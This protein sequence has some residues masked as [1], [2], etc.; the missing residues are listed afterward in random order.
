MTT[1]NA[2]TP[3]QEKALKELLSSPGMTVLLL[4]NKDID[5]VC[6][7]EMLESK[8]QDKLEAIEQKFL[9]DN[10]DS[11]ALPK[12]VLSSIKYPNLNFTK[13]VTKDATFSLFNDEHLQVSGKL[14]ELFMNAKDVDE[15]LSLGVYCRERLNPY[16][17]IYAW[18]SACIHREDTRRVQLPGIAENLPSKFFTKAVIND[19]RKLIY[20]SNLDRPIVKLTTESVANNISE[21]LRLNYFREDIAINQHHY[22][23]HIIYPFTG[24]KSV[25]N[26]DRRGELFYYLHNQMLRRINNERFCLGITAVTPLQM[27]TGLTCPD[28]YYPKM[29]TSLGSRYTTGRPDNAEISEIQLGGQNISPDRIRIWLER[30]KNSI[31][32]GH[33]MLPNEG[34]VLLTPETGMDVIGNLIEGS[35]LSLNPGYYGNAHNLGHATIARCHDPSSANNEEPGV[36]SDVTTAMRDPIFY[37]WHTMIDDVCLEYKVTL[38]FYTPDELSCDV[39]VDSVEILKDGATTDAL[40]TFWEWDDV[41][42]SRGLDFKSSTP[43]YIRFKHLNHEEWDTKITVTNK[44][45]TDTDVYVRIWLIPVNDYTQQNINLGRQRLLGLEM[46]KFR[47]TLKP[48]TQ[49]LT[50]KSEDSTLTLPFEKSF[51]NAFGDGPREDATDDTAFCLCGWPHHMFLPI[52]SMDG[53]P[54][55]VFVMLTPFEKDRV[56]SDDL[57]DASI[58]CGLRSKK[59]PDKR[60]MGF[61]FDRLFSSDYLQLADLCN[62]FE[63]M[64][65]TR[66]S[67]FHRNEERFG[68]YSLGDI[69]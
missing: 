39:S 35:M 21:E 9:D 60:S 56:D 8:Y 46:D 19:S 64:N 42:C 12:V 55:E 11:G 15:L 59:Y 67:V 31:T 58:Y 41:N 32:A 7:R 3:E 25:V 20:M 63:N 24:P 44:L 13:K 69:E 17:F 10:P 52:G 30:I 53:T 43:I 18:T 40:H 50:R 62:D 27:R 33:V 5:I 34:Y 45:D 16:M 38:P 37:R 6:P 29:D 36:M 22:H 49:T 28:G 68:K 51:P 4:K 54:F 57:G 1:Q 66:I 2:I 47:A 23:W 65:T 48:G 61:P 26:K 14:I